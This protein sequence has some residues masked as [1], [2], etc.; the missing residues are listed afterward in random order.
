ME[1]IVICVPPVFVYEVSISQHTNNYDFLL[2]FHKQ[3]QSFCR[4]FDPPTDG[5]FLSLLSDASFCS[6]YMIFKMIG[7]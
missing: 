5:S 1:I 7:F 6:V 4:L 2:E 3:S